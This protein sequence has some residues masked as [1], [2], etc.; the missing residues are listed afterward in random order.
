[1]DSVHGLVITGW[2]LLLNW[3]NFGLLSFR[4]SED[5]FSVGDFE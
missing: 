4:P 3:S 1:M 5:L 2:A